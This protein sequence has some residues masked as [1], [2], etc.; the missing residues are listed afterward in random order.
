M[1]NHKC[2]DKLSFINMN[3]KIEPMS[4]SFVY[5]KC[6]CVT[7]KCFGSTIFQTVI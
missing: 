3:S 5:K 4:F 6:L 7:S 1:M 2:I